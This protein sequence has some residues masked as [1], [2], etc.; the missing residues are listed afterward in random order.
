VDA[1]EFIK[2]QH[3]IIKWFVHFTSIVDRNYAETLEYTIKTK[4]R[5][6]EKLTYVVTREGNITGRGTPSEEV[7]T[8]DTTSNL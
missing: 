8:T 7:R 5:K 6:K 2:V 4:E 1:L 3:Y